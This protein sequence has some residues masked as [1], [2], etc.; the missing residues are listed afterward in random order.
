MSSES[1]RVPPAPVGSDEFRQACGRFPSGVV[2]ATV[3]DDKGTPHGL[4][5]SSFTSVSLAP[6][7]I[8]IC[9]GCRVTAIHH[10]RV[11]SHFGINILTE[12]QQ[13]LADRF[14]RKIEDRFE[15]I[16]WVKGDT[17]VP[18][19]PGV[20]A[21]IECAVHRVVPMGDHDI[22]VGE[23]VRTEVIAGEP[24]VHFSGKYRELQ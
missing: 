24:L 20:L 22:L 12:A 9:L 16:Q 6:P 14:A 5:V 2:V 11:A 1:H 17:G 10:F 3:L 15:G 23:V 19:L 18:L 8:L 13:S 7:L 4:T 21:A